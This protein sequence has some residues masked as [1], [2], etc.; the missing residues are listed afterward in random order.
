V[1]STAWLNKWKLE[2]SNTFKLVNLELGLHRRNI[3]DLAAT[4]G[5]HVASYLATHDA[6]S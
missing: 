1:L 3:D 2:C 6:M 5:D 4:S